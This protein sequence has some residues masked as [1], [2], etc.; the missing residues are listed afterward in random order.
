MKTKSASKTPNDPKLSDRRGWRDRCVVG[1]KAAAEAAVAPAAPVR[2]SAWLG[3]V[4][5]SLA[6]LNVDVFWFPLG[7][8]D[9]VEC[10][11]RRSLFGFVED[12]EELVW[13][14]V[15]NDGRAHLHA[16]PFLPV[17]PENGI[18]A[19]YREQKLQTVRTAMDSER[20]AREKRRQASDRQ[21]N[22]VAPE[23]ETPRP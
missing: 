18:T 2:C 16:T 8:S 12:T 13:I 17:C 11:E 21:R 7:L 9:I 10:K 4:R 20:A 22:C 15:E 14:E 19:E 1:G 6:K 3:A 5:T 23:P